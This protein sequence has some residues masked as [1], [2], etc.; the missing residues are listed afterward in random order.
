MAT[1]RWVAWLN[2]LFPNLRRD[3]FTVVGP[4]SDL[5]NCI[6]YAAGDASQWWAHIPGRYWPSHA[7]RSERLESLIE[8]FAGLGF[9]QCHD[10]QVEEGYQKVTLYEE[11]GAWTHAALQMP[12][13]HW[14]SKM[15]EGP[16]IEHPNPESLSAG[17]YGDATTF[18]R[19]SVQPAD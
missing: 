7:T 15:G 12:N 8:V 5:Y 2:A 16:V 11:R 1:R 17:P 19:K 3:G 13:G 9:E 14:R 6:A 4:Q 10:S 18:M